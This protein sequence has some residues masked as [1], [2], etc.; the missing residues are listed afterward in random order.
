MSRAAGYALLLLVAA[1]A[2]TLAAQQGDSRAIIAAP[3]APA[4]AAGKGAAGAGG[5]E[6]GSD[7]G[8]QLPGVATPPSEGAAASIGT[9]HLQR[10]IFKGSKMLPQQSLQAIAAP[11]L[12]RTLSAAQVEELRELLTR[13]YTDRGYIN[14]GVVLDASSAAPEG[15]LQFA[16]I[17]GRIREVRIRGLKRLRPRY[18]IDRLRRGA[19][20]VLNINVLRERFQS[21]L[22]DPLFA[23]INS[24]I[25]PGAQ[26]GEAILDMDVERAR[27]Y[28][29]SVA[30]NNYR[31]PSIGEK[32]YDVAGL[33]RDL[34]GWGDVLDADL[35]GALNGK[36]GVNYSVG[37]QIPFTRYLTQA[38]FRSSYSD[39]VVTE[40]PLGPLDIESRIERQELKLTQPLWASLRGQVNLAASIAYERDATS[41]AGVP[42]SFLPGAVQG[43]TRAISA[44]VA[45]DISFRNEQQY[46]GLRLTLLHATL[47]GESPNASSFAQ[48]SHDYLVSTGQLHHLLE[49]APVHLELESH[50]T[51]Q[52]TGARISDLH[53]IEVGGIESVRGFRENELLLSNVRNVNI[54]LRWLALPRAGARPGMTLGTF[55]DWASGRDVDEPETTFSS[56][57]LTLRVKWAHVQADLAVGARLIRPSFVE[58]QHGSWQD[59][60]IHAQVLAAL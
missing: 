51:A 16:V 7:Q 54:D 34:T 60:G 39:S 37:W 56:T 50:A 31:P 29:L 20:E 23:R 57:G 17:E 11:Y 14:S 52:W 21:L 6:A 28:A 24:R 25:L 1:S 55:F 43:V 32:A 4:P 26:L 53:A 33:V 22:D 19:G 47:L 35:S 49:L 8:F 44:R 10:V 3:T 27:P 59:H 13:A 45:P 36:G 58:Q 40:E 42:F 46:L 38:S 2:S 9:I 48:P 12:G 15:T 30:F 18:V 41:L 5:A